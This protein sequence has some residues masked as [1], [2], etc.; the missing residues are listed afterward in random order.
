MRDSCARGPHLCSP[1]KAAAPVA[2][3][4]WP[5][6]SFPP[7]LPEVQMIATIRSDRSRARRYICAAA[8]NFPS[9]KSRLA[10]SLRRSASFVWES[11]AGG[12]CIAF[13]TGVKAAN[14]GKPNRKATPSVARRALFSTPHLPG[15]DFVFSFSY[16]RQASC[17]N[18]NPSLHHVAQHQIL[19]KGKSEQAVRPFLAAYATLQ[20]VHEFTYVADAYFG[21]QRLCCKVSESEHAGHFELVEDQDRVRPEAP[22]RRRMEG[23]KLA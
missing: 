17:P 15:N 13:S 3:A 16:E 19:G 23:S 18:P 5:A 11:I 21:C 10:C 12:D 2:I 14:E 1:C 9:A 4:Q 8:L 6:A 7:S 22:F 20:S